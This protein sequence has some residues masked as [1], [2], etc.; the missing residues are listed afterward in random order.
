MGYAFAVFT[1][2]VYMSNMW[3]SGSVAQFVP[4]LMTDREGIEGRMGQK[5]C[6]GSFLFKQ[7]QL[8]CQAWKLD[9]VLCTECS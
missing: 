1:K 3:L 5:A 7:S 9:T 2:G 4:L 8:S 6:A